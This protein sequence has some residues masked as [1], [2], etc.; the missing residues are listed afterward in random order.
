M[1]HVP[2]PADEAYA[3]RQGVPVEHSSRLRRFSF[4]TGFTCRDDAEEAEVWR[5][6][7]ELLDAG[8]DPGWPVYPRQPPDPPTD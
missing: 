8:I 3:R 5:L 1:E 7:A 4:L 2:S 6:K